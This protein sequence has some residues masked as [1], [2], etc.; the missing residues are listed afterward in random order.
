VSKGDEARIAFI[1]KQIED[2]HTIIERH[3]GLVEALSDEVE[4]RKALLLSLE[5]LGEALNKLK[6][7]NLRNRFGENDIKGAYDV[8]TFIAH[9]YEGVNLLL[10]ERI[11]R[12]K[13]PRFESI[14]KTVLKEFGNEA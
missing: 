9:D 6:D 12:E 2:M 4:G 14:C 8:R 10:I 3:D 13:I 11:I 1:L 5:Q 7:E